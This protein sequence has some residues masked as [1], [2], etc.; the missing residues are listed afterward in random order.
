MYAPTDSTHFSTT[1]LPR[2]RI[3][4]V[5]AHL[6]GLIP[7]VGASA[8]KSGKAS[9]SAP[10]DPAL[11]QF[12]TDLKLH[13]LIERFA[14]EDIT[15]EILLNMC[16]EAVLT[17]I[18]PKVGPRLLLMAAMRQHRRPPAAAVQP[19]CAASGAS[20]NLIPDVPINM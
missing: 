18:V 5:E 10:A 16:D 11:A 15:L 13:D 17:Q 6:N 9:S 4:E 7:D 12:L 14:Q 8:S 2:G 19:A 3:P 1:Q 20:E